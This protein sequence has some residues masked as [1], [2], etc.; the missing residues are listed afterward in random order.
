MQS[1]EQ[2]RWSRTVYDRQYEPLVRFLLRR[3]RRRED[4]E[5]LAQEAFL[6]L[7][8]VPRHELIQQPDAYLFRIALNLLSEF[9]LR[10]AKSR[11]VYDSDLAEA[12]DRDEPVA[13]SPEA[14]LDRQALQAAIAALPER[15]RTALILHRRDGLTYAEIGERLGVSSNM[16]KKYL[17]T[18]IA[19]C[20]TQMGDSR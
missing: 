12:A 19:R 18:A 8:R 5:D 16:V 3:L 2:P 15:C 13:T 4:A 7:V 20:R 9:R 11:I 6:R 17:A 14:A 10:A 1:E